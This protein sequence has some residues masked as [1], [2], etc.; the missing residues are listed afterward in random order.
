[1]K[2]EMAKTRRS[3]DALPP[4]PVIHGI[5]GILRRNGRLLLIQRAAGLRVAGA[6]CFPGGHIEPGESHGDAL[7]REMREELGLGVTPG[8]H[9]FTLIKHRGRLRLHCW[10]AARVHGPLR[11]NRAEVAAAR[12]MTPSEIRACRRTSRSCRIDGPPRI[13]DGTRAILRMLGV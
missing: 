4:G 11:P 9:L 5:L 6:W 1:M 7:A 2:H 10:S 8:E 3:R 13:I 12:W